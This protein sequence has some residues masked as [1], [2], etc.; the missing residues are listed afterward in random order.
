MPKV[1]ETKTEVE[2]K[3]TEDGNIFKRMKE[4][5]MGTEA[6]NVESDERLKKYSEGEGILP[7]IERGIRS[8][9]GKKSGGSVKKTESGKDW[10]GFGRSKTGGTKY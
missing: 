1:V 2:V 8:I 3:P 5:L 6:Q 10:H 4:N 7:A 9:T